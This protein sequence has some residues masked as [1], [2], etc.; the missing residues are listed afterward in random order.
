MR[1]SPFD[2]HLAMLP[3]AR[4]VLGHRLLLHGVHPQETADALLVQFDGRPVF[5]AFLDKADR[6][7]QPFAQ[8][9]LEGLDDI[10]VYDRSHVKPPENVGGAFGLAS[11]YQRKMTTGTLQE[12]IISVVVE[13][14]NR[15]LRREWL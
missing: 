6:L 2:R 9:L 10:R 3:P 4:D 12:R 1:D 14:M 5:L 7:R 11:H 8:T 13:P 15:L